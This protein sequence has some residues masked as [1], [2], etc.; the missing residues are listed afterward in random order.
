M[1]CRTH[2]I[3]RR[4]CASYK[5][6]TSTNR[7]LHRAYEAYQGLEA[8]TPKVCRV[9]NALQFLLERSL[10]G[11]S[12]LESLLSL[13][14]NLDTLCLMVDF[15][16]LQS[17]I[18]KKCLAALAGPFST[19]LHFLAVCTRLFVVHGGETILEQAGPCF[20]PPQGVPHT[21]ISN[22]NFFPGKRGILILHSLGS[23]QVHVAMFPELCHTWTYC[24]VR[25]HT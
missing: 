4:F 9:N 6:G 18:C 2:R 17:K 7:P 16:T 15:C 12:P 24:N 1:S 14:L 13:A 10:F 5:D 3:S 21:L 25:M 22:A 23:M 11:V 19:S 20:A 8:M